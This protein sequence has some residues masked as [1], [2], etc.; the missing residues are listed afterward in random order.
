M[1]S[2]RGINTGPGAKT[3]VSQLQFYTTST[4]PTHVH[5]RRDTGSSKSARQR[6]AG[7]TY[8]ILIEP[9]QMETAWRHL[10]HPYVRTLD[11]PERRA[12][13]R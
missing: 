6:E 8:E 5:E 12:R 3:G 9:R 2:T 10:S 4:P 1:A 7:S 11:S 13:H